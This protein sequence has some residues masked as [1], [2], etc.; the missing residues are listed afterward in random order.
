MIS[1]KEA[2]L[3][4]LLGKKKVTR[5]SARQYLIENQ[6]EI[7]LTIITAYLAS[8]RERAVIND[9]RIVNFTR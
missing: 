7:P 2:Y 8:I 9:G 6:E 1:K 5:K 4:S 3:D